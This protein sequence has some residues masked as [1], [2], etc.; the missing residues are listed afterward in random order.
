[1]W[2]EYFVGDWRLKQGSCLS[3]QALYPGASSLLF[4][5]K[6]IQTLHFFFLITKVI[7]KECTT[8]LGMVAQTFNPN[9]GMGW[10]V[11]WLSVS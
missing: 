6:R 10:E 1:M 2:Q 9:T 4:D 8:N 3:T 7:Y 11:G 5:K